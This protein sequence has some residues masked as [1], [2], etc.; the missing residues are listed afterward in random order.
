MKSFR[1]FAIE[2]FVLNRRN[3][4]AAKGETPHRPS[5]G[6]SSRSFVEPCLPRWSAPYKPG[7]ATRWSGQS[8]ILVAPFQTSRTCADHLGPV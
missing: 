6:R 7:D 2:V 3:A 4:W 1:G 8:P 5:L